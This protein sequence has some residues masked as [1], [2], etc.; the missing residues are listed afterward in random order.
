[1]SLPP[2]STVV[3]QF[4][5]DAMGTTYEGLVTGIINGLIYG[6]IFWLVFTIAKMVYYKMQGPKEVTVK[7]ETNKNK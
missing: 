7:V 3:E 1:M 6:I 4:I 5:P 2:G